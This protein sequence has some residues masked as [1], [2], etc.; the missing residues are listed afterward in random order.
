MYE[1]GKTNLE[2]LIAELRHKYLTILK[3]NYWEFFEEGQCTPESVILLVESADKCMD[4]ES[5]PMKDW[6]YLKSYLL[7]DQFLQVLSGISQIPIIG[8]IFRSYLFSNFLLSYDAIVN[9][10]EAHET[11]DKMLQ[12]VIESKEFVSKILTESA[13]NVD[14][15][16]TYMNSSLHE[17]F[18]EISKAI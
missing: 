10:I 3:Q 9:F 11:T 16:D 5:L 4:D 2:E 14:E 12:A 8:G 1:Q 13:Q 18:P 6:D 17:L 15:S 7:S